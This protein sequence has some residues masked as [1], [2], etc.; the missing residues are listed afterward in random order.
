[1]EIAVA[2]KNL[3]VTAIRT[4]RKPI[5]REMDS[6]DVECDSNVQVVFS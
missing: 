1:M 2:E 4:K 5:E 3:T 6:Y